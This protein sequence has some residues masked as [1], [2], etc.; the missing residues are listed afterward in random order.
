MLVAAQDA[1][2]VEE[3][4]GVAR[5]SAPSLAD[6]DA[7]VD[8]M[9][10]VPA[11]H[12]GS[13]FVDPARVV[14]LGSVAPAVELEGLG[15]LAMVLVAEEDRLRL[16]GSAAIERATAPTTDES[17]LA[18]WMPAD[19]ELA[20]TLLGAGPI[21]EQL[22]EAAAQTDQGREVTDLLDAARG[23]APLLIGIDVD[24]DVLPILEGPVAVAAADL[25][26][27]TPSIQVLVQPPDPD[28]AASTLERLID[29]LEGFGATVGTSSRGRAE[30]VTVTMPD[31]PSVSYAIVDDVLIAG[32]NPDGVDAAVRAHDGGQTLADDAAYR[33]TVG[34][35]DGG[36]GHEIF[37]DVQ[38]I[39]DLAGVDELS[40]D[41]RDILHEIGAF[42]LT[43]EPRDGRVDVRAVLTVD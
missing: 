24:D 41:A 20:V 27:G 16:A 42:G 12:L 43:A 11:D 3:I 8:A 34:L 38:A 9:A 30:V 15:A 37:V 39:L 2:A 7:F 31:V 28:A 5:G 6:A 10:K 35:T 23:V 40:A 14:G 29:G 19:T 18:T 25:A 21:L 32:L 13:L 1:A 26:G 33:R 22:E 4:V 17:T 36:A